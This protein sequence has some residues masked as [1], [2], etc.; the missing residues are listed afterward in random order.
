MD[1]L[2]LGKYPPPDYPCPAA[3]PA[4]MGVEPF[5]L[6]PSGLAAAAQCNDE[7]FSLLD[8]ADTLAV[9]HTRL[10]WAIRNQQDAAINAPFVDIARSKWHG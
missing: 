4:G 1:R 2:Y 9:R 7:V 6:Y 10:Y 3:G 5:D 8:A